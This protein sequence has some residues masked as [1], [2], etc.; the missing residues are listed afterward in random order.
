[1]ANWGIEQPYYA[2]VYDTSVYYNGPITLV[3]PVAEISINLT[4]PVTVREMQSFEKPIQATVKDINGD[5]VA[6]QIVFA[7]IVGAGPDDLYPMAYPPYIKGQPNKLLVFPIPGVYSSD[8]SNP[9]S[10]NDVMY[11]LVTDSKGQVTFDA[12]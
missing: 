7:S 9:L 4:A 6:N 3:S 10:L 8:Y 1:V 2:S 12:L 5:P 11:P